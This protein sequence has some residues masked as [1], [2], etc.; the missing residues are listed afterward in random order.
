MANVSKILGVAIDSLSD[1]YGSTISGL[2][3]IMG[4][5]LGGS[6]QPAGPTDFVF[7]GSYT[8]PNGDDVDFF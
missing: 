2:S 1:I 4:V 8:P 6:S 3:K 5:D 7:D